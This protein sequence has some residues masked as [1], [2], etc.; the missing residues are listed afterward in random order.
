MANLPPTLIS[1]EPRPSIFQSGSKARLFSLP[2]KANLEKKLLSTFLAMLPRAPALAK[3]LL[4]TTDF[5]VG[6]TTKISVF[7]EVK[8]N[9]VS[10][11][12]SNNIFDGLIVAKTG[13]SELKALLEAK[14]G[15]DEHSVKQVTEY[16]EFAKNNPNSDIRKIITISNKFVARYDHPVVNINR[17]LLKKTRI[18][19]WS[20]TFIAT[21]CDI[22]LKQK[23]VL[24]TPQKVLLSDFLTL[25]R[26]PESGVERFNRMPK[27]WRSL[28]VTIEEGKSLKKDDVTTIS[29]CWIQVIKDISLM[30]ESDVEK[31][32]KLNFGINQ[33]CDSKELVQHLSRCI[34]D[35]HLKASI[36]I[37]RTVGKS[38]INIDVDLR[39]KS[40][41][42][43]VEL[44]APDN[45]KST[46]ARVNWLLKMIEEEAPCTHVTAI[47]PAGAR[48][49]KESLTDLR[50]PPLPAEFSSKNTAP[51]KFVV[52]SLSNTEN[53]FAGPE[54]F[55]KD[56]KES[57]Q[58]FSNF[59]REHLVV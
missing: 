11:N 12:E 57:V 20:W 23:N 56:L 52:E 28:I 35:K 41:S 39:A 46:G 10:I 16:L 38:T 3:V 36:D 6:K 8:P 18:Y 2:P 17:N 59:V 49:T 42:V 26:D 7:T 34:E 1:D 50:T 55:V 33:K 9:E 25:L 44:K 47:W 24:D 27:H 32:V 51:V 5:G 19:H 15:S 45:R 30:I 31:E 14:V 40:I 37:P 13:H 58:K 48:R 4:E 21:Q 29:E 54:T 22:L 43:S 53:R